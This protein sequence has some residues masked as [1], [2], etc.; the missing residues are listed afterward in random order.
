MLSEN[1]GVENQGS[2]HVNEQQWGCLLVYSHIR[3]ITWRKD[4]SVKWGQRPVNNNQ[5][6][7]FTVCFIALDS[8]VSHGEMLI[9]W[10]WGLVP[11]WC[12]DGCRA[13]GDSRPNDPSSDEGRV[14]S[15]I[16]EMEGWA[17]DNQSMWLKQSE[18]KSIL[19]MSWQNLISSHRP[20]VAGCA[21]YVSAT[22]L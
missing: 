8:S 9:V 10:Y 7:Y 4:V 15:R 3:I 18:E 14:Y 21:E 1:C 6:L 5:L 22:L 19:L 16:E 2:V 12:C 17:A 20:S 13:A 11:V